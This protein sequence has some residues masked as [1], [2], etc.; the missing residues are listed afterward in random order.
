MYVELIKDMGFIEP[1]NPFAE[2]EYHND[3]YEY[4]MSISF[5]ICI[6]ENDIF[7]DVNTSDMDSVLAL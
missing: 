7:V 4:H 6:S 3:F 2:I 1:I 5:S